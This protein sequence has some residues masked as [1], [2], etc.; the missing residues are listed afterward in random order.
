[1]ALKPHCHSFG[2]FAIFASRTKSFAF[3]FYFFFINF[4][5][6]EVTGNRVS[7]LVSELWH[8][9]ACLLLNSWCRISNFLTPCLLDMFHFIYQQFPLRVN[10][11]WWTPSAVRFPIRLTLL[12][13]LYAL[14][15]PPTFFFPFPSLSSVHHH[16]FTSV[17]AAELL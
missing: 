14:T 5:F 3:L 16:S 9:K 11:V 1:M 7:I 2:S 13:R 8:F 12:S 15:L 6:Y 4:V 10:P 17:S